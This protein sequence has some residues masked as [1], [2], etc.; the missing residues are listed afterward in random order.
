VL[1]EMKK[2][3]LILEI[4]LPQYPKDDKEPLYLG[5]CAVANLAIR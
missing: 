3:F 4:L 1:S 2:I 5:C